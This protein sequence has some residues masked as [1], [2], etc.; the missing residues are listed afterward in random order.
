V[1]DRALATARTVPI[2]G[3]RRLQ[4]VPVPDSAGA[5]APLACC[6]GPPD[7]DEDDAGAEL[8]AGGAV[9]TLLLALHALG[10][11]ARFQPAAPAARLA[12]A[13]ALDL[14]P[15]WEPLGFLAAGHP[16]RT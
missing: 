8:A 2:P 11:G 1:L 9:R 6:L 12:L 16:G 3:G 15:G 14:D 5:P 7:G 13:E 4:L 10:A